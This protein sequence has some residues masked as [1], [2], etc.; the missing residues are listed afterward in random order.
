MV[1]TNGVVFQAMYR[2]GRYIF[3]A[4]GLTLQHSITSMDFD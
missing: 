2:K 1:T 4:G 3:I